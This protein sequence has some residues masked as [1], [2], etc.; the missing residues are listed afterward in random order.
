[1]MMMVMMIMMMIND[2]EV[3][4][5]VF[6]QHSSTGGDTPDGQAPELSSF[7]ELGRWT[8]EFGWTC[9]YIYIYIGSRLGVP[10]YTCIY[11][12]IQTYTFAFNEHLLPMTQLHP[13]M[14][15]R[16]PERPFLPRSGSAFDPRLEPS[17]LR[18]SCG[19]QHLWCMAT[20]HPHV[21][22]FNRGFP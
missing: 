3:L 6:G 15:S 2:P 16:S 13:S 19:S 1:M 22:M 9:E 12:Y 20:G 21:F 8:T 7:C 17:S 10:L 5:R 4:L 11:I 18:D 14:V